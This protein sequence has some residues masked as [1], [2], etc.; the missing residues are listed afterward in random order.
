MM[1]DSGNAE[2]GDRVMKR[3]ALG[4][5]KTDAARRDAILDEFERSG[6]SGV[7][8]A[9]VTGIKYAT[10]ASWIQ[11]RRGA[12]GA[13]R[14]EAVTGKCVSRRGAPLRARKQA[15]EFRGGLFPSHK[16]R[17]VRENRPSMESK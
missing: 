8:F 4:R 17:P 6:L 14:K 2:L 15:G 5:V 11:R 7:K 10:L 1:D 3:D 13:C 16:K 12:H 9:A